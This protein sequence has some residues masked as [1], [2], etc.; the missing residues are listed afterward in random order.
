[1][2]R[3]HKHYAPTVH[4]AK[5]KKAV[6]SVTVSP[7]PVRVYNHNGYLSRVLCQHVSHVGRLIVRVIISGTGDTQRII[8]NNKGDNK[9]YGRYTKNNS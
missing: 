3:E 8:A 9:W 6:G 7:A 4:R 2:R 5:G 1:M